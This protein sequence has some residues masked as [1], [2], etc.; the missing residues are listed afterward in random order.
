MAEINGITLQ[1]AKQVIPKIYAYT[2]PEVR[3][4]DGWLKIGY[5]EQDDVLDRIKQQCNTID[6]EGKYEWSGNATFENS[7][8]TFTDKMFH[9]YL[10]KQGYE[11]IPNKEWIKIGVSEGKLKF[12]EFRENRGILSQG[13]G[14][15]SYDLRPEQKAAVEY[16]SNYFSKHPECEFLW[17][18]KP[19][20]GKTLATYDLCKTVKAKKVLIVTNRPSTATSWYADYEKF[21]G[22]ES[23]YRFVSTDQ[24]IK[25]KPL[26]L[27]RD[28]YESFNRNNPTKKA[29]LIEFM[30]LQ[31]MKGSVYFGGTFDKLEAE[32]REHWDLLVIDEAHEGVDTYKTDRAFDNI[33]RDC[34]LHLTGTPFKQIAGNKFANDAIFNWTYAG[35]QNAKESW[36]EE[37]A[38]PY[39]DLPKLT[40]FTYQMSDIVREKVSKGMNLD[41]T[42]ADFAFD[43]NEFFATNESG[44]FI[45]DDAVNKFLDALATQEKFPFSTPELRDELKHTFWV[46]N[47]VNSAVALAKKLKAHPVFKDYEIVSVAGDGRID[48]DDDTKNKKAYAKVIDAIHKH[49]KTITLSVGQLT[50]GVTVPEWTAVLMLSNISTPSLYM[51][52]A[53]R[54]QNPCLFKNGSE[55]KRKENSYIFDFDPARTLD[56]YEQFANNLKLS[57]VDGRGTKKE[58]EDNIKELLNFFPVYGEDKE[59]KMI[60]LDAKQVLKIPRKIRSTEVV[61]RGFMSNF[62][63]KDIGTVFSAPKAVLDILNQFTP[64]EDSKSRKKDENPMDDID[65]VTLNED[66]EVEIAQEIVIGQAKDI[67]GSKIYESRPVEQVQTIL[68]NTVKKEETDE[69]INKVDK[70]SETLNKS[71]EEYV[72]A[73]M[74]TK[75]EEALNQTMRKSE[76]NELENTLKKKANDIIVSKVEDYKQNSR[77]IDINMNKDLEN[78]TSVEEKETIRDTYKTIK[79]EA[80]QNMQKAISDDLASFVQNAA[81]ES[82]KKVNESIQNEKKRKIED[83]VRDHLRGFTR[84]IPSFLMAYG[85]MDVTLETFDTIIPDNVFKEV[86]SIT[87]DEFRFLRDGGDYTDEDGNTKHFNGNIFDAMVFNDSITEFVELKDK[88]AD[89]FDESIPE[90]I[91]DY[92]PPQKTNQIFTPK[93]I[94]KQMVDLL[95]QENPGCFDD[96]DKTFIDLYMKSGL[97]VTEIVKKLYNSP[98]LIELYPDS[99]SR[100]KHIFAKQVYG[101]APTEIIYQIVLSFVFGFDHKHSIIKEHNLRYLDALPYVEAGTLSEKLD[102]LF[103]G[104]NNA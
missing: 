14:V 52:A 29:N 58:H 46:L 48:E 4:H 47:R 28:E 87:L 33:R 68:E 77:L 79:E 50:T 22:T 41:D 44:R 49:D 59:G 85:D 83:D 40:M 6:V 88:L 18:C 60:E 53:F 3:K 25:D 91:F 102:E 38:N 104:N 10:V 82:V 103:G 13:N 86:T 26:V 94:V 19:R 62:L 23:G 98:K 64:A 95:E 61:R 84:T 96:P 34:T 32:R 57:T 11:K 69:I 65:D 89:Y 66:G 20:F 56:I 92:I 1:T 45:H 90:D 70:M 27:T 51:Q 80:V 7:N 15:I 12:Y 55:Y 67:F 31:D 75:T 35:E 8:D 21:L 100:L 5:T 81:E 54:A 73:P 78:A 72:I 71:V 39:F 99:E 37:S 2:T 9:A 16:T 43:L 93:K 74:I 97:Y 101:L 42:T 24:N 17:N 30:S 76:K 63:F 36:N